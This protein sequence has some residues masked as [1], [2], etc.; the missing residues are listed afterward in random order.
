[1]NRSQQ[2]GLTLVEMVLAMAMIVVVLSALLPQFRVMSH[3]W[4]LRQ[5]SAETLQNSRVFTDHLERLLAQ[6]VTI[7]AV[8]LSTDNNGYIEFTAPDGNNYRCDC[9]SDY[10]RFGLTGQQEMMAGPV[11]GLRFTCYSVSDLSTPTTAP[12]SVDY[13]QVDTA[14]TDST[15]HNQDETVSINVMLARTSASS[16]SGSL[17][18]HF[19]LDETAGLTAA[20]SSVNGLTGQLHFSSSNPWT[21]GVVGNA[22][23]FNGSTDV[24]TLLDHASLDL[25]DQGTVAAWIYVEAFT[26]FAGI[27]H[28]GD[29]ADFSDEAYTLQF[30]TSNRLMFSVVNNSTSIMV[31]DTTA[32]S[33]LQWHHV[34]GKWDSSG[35]YLYVDGVCHASN[36]TAI[37]ARNSSGGLNIGAQLYDDP[38]SSYGILPFNGLIDDVRIYS[39]ALSESQI[40]QLAQ[41]P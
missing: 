14:F 28:K 36:P 29:M 40:Q 8:S 19:E 33:L 7:T 31:I 9:S 30:W 26:S 24:V 10:I 25:T 38:H 11:S 12:A 16:G 32:P 22:L 5:A 20:D 37:V 34:L 2:K 6:A 39:Y 18:L 3:S 4:E 15:G 27:I 41:V 1:M 21:E 23:D 13:I 17:E 35:V